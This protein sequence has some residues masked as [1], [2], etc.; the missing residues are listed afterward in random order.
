MGSKDNK[1]TL[2]KGD[3]VKLAICPK[4]LGKVR[5]RLKLNNKLKRLRLK[6]NH[7]HETLCMADKTSIKH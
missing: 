2:G 5:V 1:I 3:L 7:R 4:G 6:N